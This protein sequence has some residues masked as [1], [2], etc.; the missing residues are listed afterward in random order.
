METLTPLIIKG[1]R[2]KQILTDQQYNQDNNIQTI[3]QNYHDFIKKNFY[4]SS[5]LFLIG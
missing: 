2:R 4:S 1:Q 3:L 5:E